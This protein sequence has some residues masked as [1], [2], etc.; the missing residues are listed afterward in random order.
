MIGT[1]R[2]SPLANTPTAVSFAAILATV[3]AFLLGLHTLHVQGDDVAGTSHSSASVAPVNSVSLVAGDASLPGG[4]PQTSCMDCQTPCPDGESCASCSPANIPTLM[5]FPLPP[6]HD[7]NDIGP[8][9]GTASEALPAFAPQK[10]HLV[11]LVE[12]SVSRV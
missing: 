7:L 1:R 9:N 4:A 2:S 11:S 3:L 5:T 8:I 12:L 6:Q 10:S